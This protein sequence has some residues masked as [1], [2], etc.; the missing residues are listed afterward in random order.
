MIK[1]LLGIV[2]KTS[3]D[4]WLLGKPAGDRH[5]RIG[6]GYLPE[7]HRIPRHHT[8]NSALE[9]YG[10]LSGMDMPSIRKRRGELLDLVGL[11]EWGSEPIKSYSKGMQQRLGLAQAMLH[12]PEL[13]VLDEPTDG[14]DPQGRT[15]IRGILK[16]LKEQGKT[17]LVNSHLL[18]EIELVCDRVAILDKGRL[19]HLGSVESIT[20]KP[21]SDI[22][23]VIAANEAA[24]RSVLES[25][26]VVSRQPVGNGQWQLVLQVPDQAAVDR[27]IDSLRA[28]GVSI[29]ELTRRRRTL[30]E[31]F[32]DIVTNVDVVT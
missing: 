5:G 2:R 30:E 13:L 31:A 10:S 26:R 3:G 14:V 23:L 9:Y 7:N 25:E 6:V 15:V 20:R 27:A 21:T 1:V 8:G 4:A 32:I 19:Q 17:I 29:V 18:H 12:D 22:T 24:A 28:A 16:Q 11:A